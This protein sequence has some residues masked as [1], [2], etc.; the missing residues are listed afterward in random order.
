MPVLVLCNK[1]A[2]LTLFGIVLPGVIAASCQRARITCALCLYDQKACK[3]CQVLIAQAESMV[4]GAFTLQLFREG[5][6][7]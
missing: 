7:N 6:D 2:A 4:H 1:F 5:I 3:R